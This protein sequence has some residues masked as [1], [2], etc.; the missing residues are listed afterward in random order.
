MYR[1]HVKGGVLE[2]RKQLGEMWKNAVPLSASEC[3][4][5]RQITETLPIHIYMY[6]CVVIIVQNFVLFT[7]SVSSFQY[8]F[9]LKYVKLCNNNNNKYKMR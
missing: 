8:E 5:N 3:T 1:V 4:T 7:T 2:I 6:V 9:T